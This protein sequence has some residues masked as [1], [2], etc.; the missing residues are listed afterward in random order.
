SGQS[1]FPE[2]FFDKR[3][4]L[5]LIFEGRQNVDETKQLDLEGLVA[6]RP[7]EKPS[8]PPGAVEQ[9]GR[10]SGGGGVESFRVPPNIRFGGELRHGSIIYGFPASPSDLEFFSKHKL[11]FAS[12]RRSRFLRFAA[13]NRRSPSSSSRGF[14]ACARSRLHWA[15]YW[16]FSRRR[17]R[18]RSC[19][20]ALMRS[21]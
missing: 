1:G 9:A 7:F 18:P 5:G 19:L 16:N 10:R 14:F 4:D 15:C 2:V 6:D 17:A 8:G 11:D 20:K 13:S 21:C 12:W 3:F